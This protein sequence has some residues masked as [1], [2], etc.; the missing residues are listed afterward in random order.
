[1]LRKVGG[2]LCVGEADRIDLPDAPFL[3]SCERMQRL[4]TSSTFVLDRAPV[5]SYGPCGYI[6][7]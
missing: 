6:I 1:M 4:R 5:I 3:L 7:R 2:L